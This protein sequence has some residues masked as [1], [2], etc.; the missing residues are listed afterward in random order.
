MKRVAN[1][2]ERDWLRR[3]FGDVV[4]FGLFAWALGVLMG[5]GIYAI[6]GN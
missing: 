2:T 5:I 4:M 3:W 6:A 1:T